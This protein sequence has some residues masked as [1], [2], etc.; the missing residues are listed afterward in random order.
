MTKPTPPP[1]SI[2][3]DTIW[4]GVARRV[5]GVG[6]IA[7]PVMLPWRLLDA[8]IDL[9]IHKPAHCH[10]LPVAGGGVGIERRQADGTFSAPQVAE[11]LRPQSA[12]RTVC[13]LN[14]V[15]PQTPEDEKEG[16]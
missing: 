16:L 9:L 6:I 3:P 4:L 7:P 15:G 13:G 5:L 1:F 10:P 12:P 8:L 2:T 14:C 11:S